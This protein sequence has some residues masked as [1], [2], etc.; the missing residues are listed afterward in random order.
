MNVGYV[1]TPANFCILSEMMIK[2]TKNNREWLVLFDLICTKGLIEARISSFYF[3]SNTWKIHTDVERRLPF[4][5]FNS[6][7]R[8]IYFFPNQTKLLISFLFFDDLYNVYY[9]FERKFC[10]R[11]YYSNGNFSFKI[12]PQLYFNYLSGVDEIFKS[13]IEIIIPEKRINTILF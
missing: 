10:H 13:F 12:L 7:F 8:V 9:K 1:N 4:S 2:K 6:T 11:N 3:I 5:F